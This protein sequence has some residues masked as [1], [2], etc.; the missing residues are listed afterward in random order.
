MTALAR[1]SLVRICIAAAVLAHAGVAGA[2]ERSVFV[3]IA[4]QVDESSAL[5]VV[6]RE[7]LARLGADVETGSADTVD[8]AAIIDKPARFAPALARV[9]VDL[10]PSDHAMVYLVDG[11]W[12]RVLVR[13]VE[14]DPAHLEVCREDIGRILETAVE[15]MLAGAKIGVERIGMTAPPPLPPASPIRPRVVH[16]ARQ[17]RGVDVR[18]GVASENDRFSDQVPI[19]QAVGAWVSAETRP[20]DDRVR[21]GAWL[22]LAYRF[23]LRTSD[24]PIGVE[25]QGIAARLVPRMS[26][27]FTRA[28]RFEAGAGPGLDVM[29]AMAFANRAGATL[30]PPSADVG[31]VVRVVFGVRFWNILGV[32][33]TADIDVTRHD[34]TFTSNGE[35]IVALSP[36]ALRPTFVLEAAF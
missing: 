35:R 27:R 28:V 23:P 30:A 6:V 3:V 25:L 21:G 26:F 18:V 32:L 14:R 16:P 12:D 19:V 17:P 2:R 5:E 15:A 8:S 10:R 1:V 13:R 4:G 31:F 7:L 24:L 20:Y 29:Q 36:Y 33:L 9:W 34:Y 11:T 22:T